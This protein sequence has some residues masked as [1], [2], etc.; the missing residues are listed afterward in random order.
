M[1]TRHLLTVSLSLL[2]GCTATQLRYQTLNQA[3]TLESLTEKQIF[4]N[5]ERF[6]Q[7]PYALPSQVTVEAGSASTT[8]TVNPMFMAPLGT[9]SM[10]ATAI[11][12]T[13]TNTVANAPATSAAITGTPP[14]TTTTTMGTTGTPITTKTTATTTG[15]TTTY[16]DS[17]PNRSLSLSVTDNWMESWTLDPVVNADVLRRLSALYRYVLG[18]SDAAGKAVPPDDQ[19]Y[20]DRKALKVWAKAHPA[21]IDDQFMCEYALAATA[22]GGSDASPPMTTTTTTQTLFGGSST[23]TTTAPAPAAPDDDSTVTLVFRCLSSG[24]NTYHLRSIKVKRSA[25]AL[26]GCVICMDEAAPQKIDGAK[27]VQAFQSGHDFVL[28]TTPYVNPILKFGFITHVK[29]GNV[30]L[31]RNFFGDVALQSNARLAFHD[32]EAF[33]NAATVVDSASAT[34]GGA[35][36]GA[37]GKVLAVPISPN[38]FLL[39]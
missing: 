10:V 21:A 19:G 6:D 26:P 28:A 18:E 22:P 35:A 20:P 3:G 12:D 23:T 8:D 37:S 16:T 11:S 13:A 2:C 31:G 24:D 5:L 7:N 14:D 33:L 25:L 27:F 38:G 4:F 32:L 39:K 9:S 1:R 34:K 30:H 15:P 29:Q 36:K 17:H